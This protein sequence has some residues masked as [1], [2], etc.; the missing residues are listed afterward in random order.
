MG[1][2]SL[3]ESFSYVDAKIKGGSKIP[4]VYTYKAILGASVEVVQYTSVWIQNVFFGKQKVVGQNESLKAYSLSDIDVSTK[5]VQ[6]SLSAG[7]RNIFD[8][9]T[10]ITITQMKL[11]RSLNMAI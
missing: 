2:L 7:V 3:N 4:N 1:I 6:V 10:M 11:T 5:I 9:F 8:T